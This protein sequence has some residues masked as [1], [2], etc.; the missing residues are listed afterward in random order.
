MFLH[1]I[2]QLIHLFARIEITRRVIGVADEDTFCARTDHLL[3]VVD[4]R[5]G[6]ALIDGAHD[7]FDDGARGDGKRHI[8]G[9]RRFGHD[10][11]IA[12]IE[13]GEESKQHGF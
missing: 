3:E 11:L 7:G 2:A 4:G 9:I 6:K 8:I 1:Q 12:G 5:Q 13:A 10:N